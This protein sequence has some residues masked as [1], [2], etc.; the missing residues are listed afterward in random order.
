MRYLI[1]T[2]PNEMFAIRIPDKLR[3]RLMLKALTPVMNHYGMLQNDIFG[4]IGF[5]PMN[6]ADSTSIGLLEVAF[7]GSPQHYQKFDLWDWIGDEFILVRK[8][9]TR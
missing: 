5:D 2:C 3:W 1:P 9:V 7:Q 6:E 8:R 4:F